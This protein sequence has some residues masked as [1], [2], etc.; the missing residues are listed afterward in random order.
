[1]AVSAY[2]LMMRWPARRAVSLTYSFSSARAWRATETGSEQGVSVG[3]G[4]ATQSYLD[5]IQ[6]MFTDL[7]GSQPPH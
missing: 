5:L 7:P 2:M 3:Q 4:R 6:S 1:M